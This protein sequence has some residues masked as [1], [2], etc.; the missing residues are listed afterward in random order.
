M[1]EAQQTRHFPEFIQ[2]KSTNRKYGILCPTKIRCFRIRTRYLGLFVLLSC[3][4]GSVAR[5]LESVPNK[6]LPNVNYSILK[7]M[8]AIVIF[9]GL[10]P[11]VPP[12][13]KNAAHSKNRPP[14]TQNIVSGITQSFADTVLCEEPQKN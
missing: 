2:V 7:S 12:L 5:F 9:L 6:L 4:R 13:Q 11:I 3:N 1:K 8:P 14:L 10:K